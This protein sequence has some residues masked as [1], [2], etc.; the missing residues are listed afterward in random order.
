MSV[1]FYVSP[2]QL[3][4]DRADFARKGIARGRS[5]VVASCAEGVLFV[6]EN[7]S[8][9]LRKIAEIHDR[10]GFAGVGK[11]HEF[12]SLR[13]AGIRYAD[14]R[15]YSYDRADVTARALAGAYAQTLGATFALHSKPFEVEILLAQ[16][17]ATPEEDEIYRVAYD[18]SVMDERGVAVAGGAAGAV[19]AHL[20]QSLAQD[21]Q[22]MAQD[23][24]AVASDDE[25]AEGSATAGDRPG[26]PLERMLRHA[27][28]A[29][30]EAGG[31]GTGFPGAG[32]SAA[33]GS[34]A[35][36]AG[37]GGEEPHRLE[38]A[39][40]DRSRPRRTFRRLDALTTSADAG[41]GPGH[42]PATS[43]PATQHPGHGTAS[44]HPDHGAT[45]HLDHGA[46]TH[47]GHGATTHPG[48]GPA[49]T[50]GG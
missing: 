39:L 7:P 30:R 10:I 36:S 8:P 43:N 3:I 45:T 19:A 14:L 41:S 34:G 31:S 24:Q 49:T 32:G 42:A 27:T 9:S 37:T 17:G 12:E 4:A 5:V 25:A 46:T 47:P 48:H 13:V 21:D 20:A 28:R 23:D 1:P 50:A 44:T 38:V 16:L 15:A 29:L 2:E 11:Y 26:I 18:G 6:A 40:L 33:G 35:G 22:A